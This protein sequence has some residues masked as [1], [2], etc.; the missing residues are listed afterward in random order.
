M[1]EYTFGLQLFAS[2]ELKSLWL[3]DV[4]ITNQFFSNFAPNFAQLKELK[5]QS[6]PGLKILKISSHSLK[7]MDLG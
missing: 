6:Y 3:D 2:W 7:R 1:E 4:A 5:I